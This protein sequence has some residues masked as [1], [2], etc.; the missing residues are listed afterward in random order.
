[1]NVKRILFCTGQGIG[2]V[3]QCVPVI[4]TL[5]KVLGYEIDFLRAYG[6]Y[7][8]PKNL[9]PNVNKIFIG[10]EIHNIDSNDYYGKVYTGWIR[11]KI[12]IIKMADL[13]LKMPKLAE[14]AKPISIIRS[15]VD[16]NMDIARRLGVKEEDLIW[17]GECNYNKL[18]KSKNKYDIVIHNGYNKHGDI[19]WSVKSYPY[20]TQVVELLKEAGLSVCS[21]GAKNEYIDGTDD[22]TGLDLLTTGGIIKN[23]KLFLSNDSGLY[24]YANALGVKNIVIFTATS[25]T[26]NY[27]KRF[28]KYSTLIYRKDL[29]CRPCQGKGGWKNC[30]TWE[31]RNIEPEIVYNSVRKL[32]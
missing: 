18:K 17:Y 22:K 6:N 14:A 1:M 31:C 3:I 11:H 23:C 9:L 26:K 5:E 30:K 21:V 25:I 27:D 29:K 28:H 19:N 32:V 4:K 24:H 15:E 20:Y 12:K 10:H 2:N 7:T 16:I 13:I 8:I